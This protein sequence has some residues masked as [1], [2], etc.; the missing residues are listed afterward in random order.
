M[1]IDTLLNDNTL[2]KILVADG[3]GTLKYR[4]ISTIFPT[5][6]TTVVSYTPASTGNPVANYNQYVKNSTGNIYYIDGS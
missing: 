4:D 1:R 3:S 5:I 2:T 6:N